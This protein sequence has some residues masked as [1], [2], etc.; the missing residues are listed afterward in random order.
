[1]LE[2][3]V[4]IPGDGVPID[5]ALR[6][7]VEAYMLRLQGPGPGGNAAMAGLLERASWP[8]SLP[9]VARLWVSI[10]H[11]RVFSARYEAGLFDDPPT[12][13]VDVFEP[14]GS[15]VGRLDLPGGFTPRRFAAGAVYGVATDR[16]DVSYAVRYRL[17]EP[18]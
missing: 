3:I 16:L 10:P 2:R 1:V 15:Y 6:S 7:R 8:E 17:Q 14:D 11:G 12:M 5:D 13:R 9:R 18:K 4:R